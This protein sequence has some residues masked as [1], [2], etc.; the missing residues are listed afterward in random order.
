M[1]PEEEEPEVT[2]P[3][4]G[5]PVTLDDEFCP[6]CGAEFE[7]EEVEEIVEVEESPEEA[8]PDE[9]LEEEF[10]E[11]LEEP[12]EEELKEPTEEEE[13][14]EEYEEELEEPIEVE[15]E[16]PYEEEY[17]EEEYEVPAEE[18]AEARAVGDLIAGLFDIRVF[19][20]A[21]LIL[22]ILGALIAIL[23]NW[24]WEWVPPISDNLG[25]FSIIGVVIIVIGFIGFTMLR[26]A[27]SEGKRPSPM[28]NSILLGIF[29]FGIIAII[30]ILANQPINDAMASSQGG[31]AG[32]FGVL[33]IVG[34]LLVFMGQKRAATSSG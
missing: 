7:E 21:L 31:M 17:I 2:C 27:A 3:V 30:M 19:G 34:V 5:N 11:E 12:L 20:I 28:M 24:L 26:R 16:E 1:P 10:D 9:E 25:M 22:G 23:I 15:Y 29:V 4:C 14:E 13:Y 32:I 6:H 33:L 8:P 18:K